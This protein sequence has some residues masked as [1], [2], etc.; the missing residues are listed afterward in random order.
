MLLPTFSFVR[1]TDKKSLTTLHEDVENHCQKAI[2]IETGHLY[3]MNQ[4]ITSKKLLWSSKK[5]FVLLETKTAR[6]SRRIYEKL[7]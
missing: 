6:S 4:V 2:N 5:C 7:S 1:P 3:Y